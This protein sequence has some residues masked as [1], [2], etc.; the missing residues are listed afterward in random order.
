[1]K[2]KMTALLLAMTLLLTWGTAVSAAD[3]EPKTYGEILFDLGLVKGTDAGLEEDKELNRAQMIAILN[4]LSEREGEAAFTPPVTPTFSD[5]PKNHWAYADIE[6]AYHNGVTTGIGGGKFGAGN[7]ITYQQAVTLLARVA[8]FDIN[9]AN[10]VEEGWEI[11]IALIGE[12]APTANLFR[13]DV[14]ELMVW[15]LVTS[16]GEDEEIFLIH[17]IPSISSAKREVFLNMDPLSMYNPMMPVF[18]YG[19]LINNYEGDDKFIADAAQKQEQY[20]TEA[21]KVIG[22]FKGVGEEVDFAAFFK[23]A[24][25]GG[26]AIALPYDWSVYSYDEEIGEFGYWGST[27][28]ELT[29]DGMLSGDVQATE[30]GDY[31][32]A[33]NP[34]VWKYASVQVDGKAVDAYYVLMDIETYEGELETFEL[35]VLVDDKGVYKAALVG[36]HGDG[37][38]V[39]E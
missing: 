7:K 27:Y 12:K 28:A 4:R 38:Y 16:Q 21:A 14:F 9:Y 37:A 3:A 34:V 24:A 32:E 20:M 18:E 6:K 29:A 15:T 35:F 39:R 22:A 25:A 17:S 13:G 26:Q 8:G 5:V 2:K 30:G 31:F 23:A 11:G 36:V 19:A 33:A 1:M 10:A